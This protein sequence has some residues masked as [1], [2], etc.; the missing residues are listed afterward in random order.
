MGMLRDRVSGCSVIDHLCCQH[1]IEQT[2]SGL[3]RSLCFG[4]S[5]L[6]DDIY[7]C[8]PVFTMV[9]PKLPSLRTI[10]GGVRARLVSQLQL[11]WRLAFQNP[12]PAWKKK[13]VLHGPSGWVDLTL[14]VSVVGLALLNWL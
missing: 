11:G 8:S 14:F 2:G 9:I 12:T 10:W 13:G 7:L 6:I 1:H 3:R 4:L 5:I